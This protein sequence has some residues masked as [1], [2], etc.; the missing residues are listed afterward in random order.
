MLFEGDGRDTTEEY[1]KKYEHGVQTYTIYFDTEFYPGKYLV[2]G[3]KSHLDHSL[4]DEAFEVVDTIEE[5]RSKI[6]PGFLWTA[7]HPR[8][9]VKIVECWT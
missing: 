2:R 7:R 1:R 9:D 5:A 4:P 6:P 3:W 8:D